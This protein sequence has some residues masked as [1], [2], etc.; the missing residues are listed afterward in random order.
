MPNWC[1]NTFQITGSTDSIKDLWDEA[2]KAEGLLEAIK[3]IPE[4]LKGTTAPSKDGN[5]WYTWC[6]NNWGTKWDVGLEGLV[7][8]DNKD[9]TAVIEGWFDSAWGPP[10]EAMQT[11]ADDFDSCHIELYYMESGMTFVGYWDSEGADDHY[12]Y[13]DCNSK[14]LRDV[15]PEYLVDHFELDEQLAMW[16]EEEDQTEEVV[17]EHS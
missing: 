12:D 5:D 4:E 9:G 17:H 15:I 7:Y 1:N 6:V 2:Q 14:T 16:E 8:S 13:G 10:S 3:P 11:L